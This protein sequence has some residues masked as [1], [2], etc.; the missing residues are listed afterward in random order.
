M[1]TSNDIPAQHTGDRS[2]IEEHLD[3]STPRQAHSTFVEASRRLLNVNEWGELSGPLS[4]A[5]A[6]T[7]SQGSTLDRAPKPGDFIRINIPGPGTVGGEGYDWVRIE[8]IDDKPNPAGNEES[9]AMRVRPAASPINREQDVAHFFDDTATSTFMIERKDLRVTAS[10]HGRNE[11]PNKD[12]ERPI[13]KMRNTVVANV[14]TS[15]VASR[16]W[17][18]LTK[19]ILKDL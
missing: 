11:Q 15:G 8:S 3:T 10:V 19:G 16:Q 9:L 6:L 2:D 17:T 1:K 14:A 5:F 4:A 13:D 18:M 7:D 12:V